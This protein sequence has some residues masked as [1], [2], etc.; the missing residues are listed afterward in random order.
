[1]TKDHFNSFCKLACLQIKSTIQRLCTEITFSLDRSKA[2]Q[3][4][5]CE[6]LSL[7]DEVTP[8]VG[9]VLEFPHWP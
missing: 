1:M 3:P 6:S 2:A 9:R 5:K 4:Y 7:R 8:L